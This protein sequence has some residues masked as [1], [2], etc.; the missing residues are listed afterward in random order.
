MAVGQR[1]RVRPVDGRPAIDRSGNPKVRQ[2]RPASV[3]GGERV[4]VAL[5]LGWRLCPAPRRS[6]ACSGNWPPD[7]SP[8]PAHSENRHRPSAPR[9]GRS[10]R[11][12]GQC[13]GRAQWRGA[14]GSVRRHCGSEGVSRRPDRRRLTAGRG[15]AR[16]CRSSLREGRLA[17]WRWE[18]VPVL[19]TTTGLLPGCRRSRPRD[20]ADLRSAAPSRQSRTEASVAVGRRTVVPAATA[21][22]PDDARWGSFAGLCHEAATAPARGRQRTGQ[23]PGITRPRPCLLPRSRTGSRRT[24]QSGVASPPSRVLT[25]GR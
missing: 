16:G 24:A 7:R 5:R 19:I 13:L 15:S 20:A 1:H 22:W 8:R 10:R 17:R 23:K 14:A 3:N 11:R 21:P 4:R 25:R 18:P 2:H 9:R 12:S 6:P